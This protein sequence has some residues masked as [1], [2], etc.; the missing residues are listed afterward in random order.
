MQPIHGPTVIGW[1]VEIPMAGEATKSDDD[2]GMLYLVI[3]VKQL[4][5]DNTC[6]IEFQ[7]GDHLL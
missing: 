5:A 7:A 2:A 6:G 3:R 1:L 4:G